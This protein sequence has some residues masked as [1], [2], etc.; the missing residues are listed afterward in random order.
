MSPTQTDPSVGKGKKWA[1]D[2]LHAARERSVFMH[3]LCFYRY[4]Q[5]TTTT[6]RLIWQQLAI[7]AF[8]LLV[9]S[10]NI[11]RIRLSWRDICSFAASLFPEF[12]LKK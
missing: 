5:G 12:S 9:C 8:L 4:L 3:F 11:A 2:L 7:G 6:A 1:L 10:N